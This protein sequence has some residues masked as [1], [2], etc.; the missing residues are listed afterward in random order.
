VIS[1]NQNKSGQSGKYCLNCARLNTSC[2]DIPSDIDSI[3][4]WRPVGCALV[5]FEKESTD[6]HT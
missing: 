3:A 1:D 4:C 6:E 2:E 5:W